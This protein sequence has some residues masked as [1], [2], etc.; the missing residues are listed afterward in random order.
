MSNP[1]EQLTDQQ[2]RLNNLYHIV[3]KNGQRVLF[4]PNR[5]QSMFMR[6]MHF[7][8]VILKARQ[9]GF[10]T[11][12]QIYM[13]D[14]AL[15]H[16]NTAC[17]VIA[18]TLTDAEKLFATKLKYPYDNL[19]EAIRQAVPT[20]KITQTEVVF[21]NNSSI[22]VGTSLRSGTLQYLHISEFGKI[23]ARRPDLAREIVTGA[24]N[25]QAPG[26]FAFIESTA[27]GR[28]GRFFEMC[29]EARTRANLN[30]P[31]NPLDFKFHF[32]PWW[33]DPSYRLPDGSVDVE[34]EAHKYFRKLADEHNINLTAE[35]R[36][37]W[38]SKARLQKDDMLREFPSTPEEA[39]AAAI[40]GSYYGS[41]IEK[42]ERAGRIAQVPFN[43]HYEVE[44]WWDL[45]VSDQTAIIFV[46]RTDTTVRIIDYY[47][48]S[49]KSLNEYANILREKAQDHGYRYSRHVMPHDIRQRDLSGT[50]GKDRKTIA[51]G[52]GIR[53]IVVAPKLE[54]AAGIDAARNLIATTYFDELR[55][56]KLLTSLR[57]YRRQWD[58]RLGTWK[59]QP[60]HD[61]SSHAADAFRYGA[62]VPAPVDSSFNEQLKYPAYGLI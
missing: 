49:G 27:E 28:E 38:A 37:W 43:P 44:T 8:N 3:D 61:W 16:P 62:V 33:Q 24:L 6:E 50:D 13:L 58:D 17:G 26:S 25:T 18:H 1:L 21:K 52:F 4:K 23:C 36:A 5:A 11:F 31:L 2:W 53:P 35:Q 22:S 30:K 10:S 15:F 34:P 45:G 42:A 9:L 12:I 46:Q 19:P 51:E 14:I 57:N 29:Q 47:E 20:E 56:E 55:A 59:D 7:N 40:E 41:Y 39:F 32:F 60:L 48:A 54:V